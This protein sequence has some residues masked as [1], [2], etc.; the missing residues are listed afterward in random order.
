M[1]NKRDQN[2]TLLL[3]CGTG[4]LLFCTASD[5]NFRASLTYMLNNFIDITKD[6]V[7]TY[8]EDLENKIVFT[9]GKP[10]VLKFANDP[11]FK[12][13][14]DSYIEVERESQIYGIGTQSENIY[15]QNGKNR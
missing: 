1:G 9:F 15:D 10:Y 6:S 7:G 4:F 11:I 3:S 5:G 12:L 2:A 8:R 13:K 14:P